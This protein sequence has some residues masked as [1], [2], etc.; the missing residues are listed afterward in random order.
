MSRRTT[1][2]SRRSFD[3]SAIVVNDALTDAETVPEFYFE[4]LGE[5]IA[6]ERTRRS[7]TGHH[8][9]PNR[10]AMTVLKR[11]VR[12]ALTAL[13][14]GLMVR[15]FFNTGNIIFEAHFVLTRNNKDVDNMG[16][17]YQDVFQGIVYR[18]DI[19]VV[20]ATYSKEIGPVPKTTIVI[21]KTN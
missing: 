6:Q 1:P 11:H 18:D 10:N 9:N 7:P 12:D 13:G 5:P 19:Q 16:K 20:S 17:F 21:K 3:V 8:Y 15:P 2:R 4:V 14:E